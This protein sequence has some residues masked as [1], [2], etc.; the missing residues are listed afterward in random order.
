MGGVNVL[1]DGAGEEIHV[2][3]IAEAK[4]DRMAMDVNVSAF[5]ARTR[6]PT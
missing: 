5:S 6:S 2:V 1:I 4:P 3:V